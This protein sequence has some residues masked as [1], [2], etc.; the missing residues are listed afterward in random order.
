VGLAKECCSKDKRALRRS[1]ILSFRPGHLVF[2][3]SFVVSSPTNISFFPAR[4]CFSFP[5][6]GIR[7]R[8]TLVGKK[9]IC[10]RGKRT[11]SSTSKNHQSKCEVEDVVPFQK[12]FSW[13]KQFP[14][15]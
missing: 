3:Q 15:T 6:K 12:E 4:R 7:K 5:H 14:F 9:E 11:T 2:P 10:G 8:K 13:K 1:S